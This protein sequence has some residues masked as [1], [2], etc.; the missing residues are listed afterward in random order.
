MKNLG[1]RKIINPFNLLKV[2][3]LS[4]LLMFVACDDD[5]DDIVK[6]VEKS[7]F[8]NGVFVLNQGAMTAANAS[9]SFIAGGGD[10]IVGNLFTEITGAE[11]LGDVLQDMVTVDTLSFLVLNASHNLMVVNNKNFEYVEEITEGL[12]SPRYAVVHDGLIYVSQ[13]GNGG[14]VVVVDPK[15]L[16]VVNTIKVDV[17]PEGLTVVNDE[18]WVANNGG[19]IQ[20]NTI[21]VIN[22]STGTVKKTIEVNDGPK[23]MVEDANGDVWALCAGYT[24]YDPDTWGVTTSTPPAI[25][26]FD[27]NTYEV[28]ETFNPDESVYGKPTHIA[29]AADGESIYFG[30]AYGF[31]GVWELAID[32]TELPQQTFA[33]DTPNGMSVNPENGDVYIGIAPDYTNPGTVEVYDTSGINIATYKE[34]IGVGPCNFIFF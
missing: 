23:N 26:K 16:K 28:I 33:D 6:P 13:W 1:L 15:E 32:A 19:I 24:E 22:L 27:G 4:L 25:Y 17:G 20:N 12:D 7:D 30:G 3:S 8:T 14:E 18:L 34:N 10:S 29:L 2:F 11:V 9:V 31:P 21:S 5:D